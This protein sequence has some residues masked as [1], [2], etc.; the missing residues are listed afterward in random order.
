MFGFGSSHPDNE[1]G[2]VRFGGHLEK[3]ETAIQCVTREVREESSLDVTFY[4][5]KITYIET[6]NGHKRV[7]GGENINPI[8]ISKN[9]E[10]KYSVIYLTYGRGTIA[11]NMET[12]GILFL[13]REDIRKICAGGTSFR[14]FRD[15]GGKYLLV[16]DLPEDNILSPHTQIRFLNELF[17]LEDDLMTDYIRAG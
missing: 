9:N 12:Q 8:L 14:E 5:N 17:D 16:K 4:D 1:L 2:V 7:N 13:R 6:E 11:P 10:N 15:S 3:G